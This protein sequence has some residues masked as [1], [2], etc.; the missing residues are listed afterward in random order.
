MSRSMALWRAFS[1][2]ANGINW[3]ELEL[4]C[5]G[6]GI[7]LAMGLLLRWIVWDI[8]SGCGHFDLLEDQLDTVI[9]GRPSLWIL[10]ITVTKVFIFFG[11][12]TTAPSPDELSSTERD[13]T[14]RGWKDTRHGPN[15][16][17]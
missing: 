11:A 13:T 12:R 9:Q 8:F 4:G 10:D 6:H 15:E 1:A 14:E 5:F 16:E 2:G 7:L 17:L 3:S